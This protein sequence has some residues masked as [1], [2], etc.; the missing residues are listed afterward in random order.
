MKLL[1]TTIT[2][3][4]LFSVMS[5]EEIQELKTKKVLWNV[6]KFYCV[7]LYLWMKKHF[8]WTLKIIYKKTLK[9]FLQLS[10]AICVIFMSTRKSEKSENFLKNLEIQKGLS[11]QSKSGSHLPGFL[12]IFFNDCPSK[13]MKNGFYFILK[14]L[15]ILKIFKFLS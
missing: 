11:L 10:L 15:F 2:G 12:F 8:Q 13:M 6:C 1:F 9:W 5:F 7:Q 14:A 4:H 3:T